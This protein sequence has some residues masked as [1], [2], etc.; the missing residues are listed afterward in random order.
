MPLRPILL[1][2]AL[3]GVRHRTLLAWA[4]GRLVGCCGLTVD[5]APADVAA[6]AGL[7]PG[8]SYGLLT[9]LAVDPPCRRRGVAAR[10]LEHAEAQAAVQLQAHPRVVGLLVAR[11][12]VDALRLYLRQGYSEAPWVDERWQAEAEKGEIGRPRRLLLIKR[13]SEAA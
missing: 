13:L 4:G 8:L 2:H 5:T 12:N 3:Y 6:A 7:P 10:L 9:G 1:Q 11:T